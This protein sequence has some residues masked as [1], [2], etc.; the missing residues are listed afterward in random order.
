MSLCVIFCCCMK[1]RASVEG[2]LLRC[3]GTCRPFVLS[4]AF[5]AGSQRYGDSSC[6]DFYTHFKA[7]FPLRP[8]L[9]SDRFPLPV[10]TGRLD[11]HAF[12]LA[13]NSASGNRALA[14]V[15]IVVVFCL[16]F[17]RCPF[18]SISHLRRTCG[19]VLNRMYREGKS[20]YKWKVVC[21]NLLCRK[22]D[23]NQSGN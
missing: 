20:S 2:Q 11:G 16:L 14:T 10:N 15:Y 18:S 6:I 4:R 13:V 12:P 3:S 1:H 9:T 17:H 21:K 8:E 7:R 22:Y 19:M 5:F 23:T